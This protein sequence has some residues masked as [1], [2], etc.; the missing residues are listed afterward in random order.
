[1]DQPSSIDAGAATGATGNA[2]SNGPRPG[3]T[4][5]LALSCGGAVTTERRCYRLHGSFEGSAGDVFL[6]VPCDRDSPHDQLLILAVTR[7]N[8][9]IVGR[10]DGTVCGGSGS[11]RAIEVGCTMPIDLVSDAA[12][13]LKDAAGNCY[14]I[15]GTVRFDHAAA[16]VVVSPVTAT[17]LR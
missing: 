5:A 8:A 10:V 11:V 7:S 1:M 13:G 3:P 4:A 6:E 2:S 9:A 17:R 15:D 16:A 14:R 12:V